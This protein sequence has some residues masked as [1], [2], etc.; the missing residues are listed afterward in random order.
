MKIICFLLRAAFRFARSFFHNK[1]EE[2]QM[3]SMMTAVAALAVCGLL[4]STSAR[5][6]EVHLAG[7]PVQVGNQCWVSTQSDQGFGY[8]RDCAK[9]AHA[10]KKK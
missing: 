5:A 8:W 9:P 3:R 6:E 10:S 4:A 1:N 2:T 7:G